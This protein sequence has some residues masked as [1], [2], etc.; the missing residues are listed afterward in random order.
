MHIL[1]L[2]DGHA[3]DM[4]TGATYIELM[5]DSSWLGRWQSQD[6]STLTVPMGVDNDRL[7]SE[8]MEVL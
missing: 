6:S 5:S 3:A 2:R 4:Y 1:L 8:Y 7:H